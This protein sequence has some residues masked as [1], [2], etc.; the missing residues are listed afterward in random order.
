MQSTEAHVNLLHCSVTSIAARNILPTF[1][2]YF[3][4]TANERTVNEQWRARLKAQEHLLKELERSNTVNQ[5]AAAIR[6]ASD[7]RRV[8]QDG[9]AMVRSWS[10]KDTLATLMPTKETRRRKG[11]RKLPAV[12]VASTKNPTCSSDDTATPREEL[13]HNFT[14]HPHARPAITEDAA[15]TLSQERRPNDN[16]NSSMPSTISRLLLN[17]PAALDPPQDENHLTPSG[18]GG[19]PERKEGGGAPGIDESSSHG[20]QAAADS[21]GWFWGENAP[22][23]G[24]DINTTKSNPG[25]GAMGA[26]WRKARV[27]GAAALNPHVAL[28]AASRHVSAN[29]PTRC[30]E[31]PRQDPSLLAPG[32]STVKLS[33]AD[34]HHSR[35]R[36]QGDRSNSGTFIGVAS[37]KAAVRS[38]SN[39]A[40]ELS[41]LLAEGN[42]P[43]REECLAKAESAVRAAQLAVS[44]SNERM[45]ELELMVGA[46]VAD[47]A[48]PAAGDDGA[49]CGGKENRVVTKSGVV[50]GV[51]VD[52]PGDKRN[53]HGYHVAAAPPSLL[54]HIAQL[55]KQMQ[56]A[57]SL[58]AASL[59]ARARLT[60]HF[61]REDGA[62]T[63]LQARVR[64]F[65]ARSRES[66]RRKGSEMTRKMARPSVQQAEITASSRADEETP[67]YFS[68]PPANASTAVALLSA[69]NPRKEEE[70]A[71]EPPSWEAEEWWTLA[72]EESADEIGD[73]ED[74]LL[75]AVVKLQAIVRSRLSRA[76][77]FAD[78]D[79][80]FVEHFDETY[81][82]PFYVCTETNCSQWNRP[83][84]FGVSLAR[85]DDF[86]SFTEEQ[87]SLAGGGE[88]ES[89]QGGAEGG[90]DETTAQ[91]VETATSDD[92][93]AC[94]Q[95]AAV[96]IQCAVRAARARGRLAE[97]IVSA[98]F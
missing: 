79:A 60:R 26:F 80:R 74:V 56:L 3:C 18:G 63:L 93:P 23:R 51:G 34:G 84:G 75:S 42:N 82:H 62:A 11:R 13:A 70:E 8:V 41:R 95:A 85:R 7:L 4:A 31:S 38:A 9:R 40:A 87:E 36:P 55:T 98:S 68:P 88:E 39:R 29:A 15:V 52:V 1:C 20:A 16:N 5:Q 73:R 59:A 83:F 86:S 25:E 89:L 71:A 91:K 69:N 28:P 2:Y 46:T 50:E 49:D 67:S 78:V 22:H 33:A 47:D 24:G 45:F 44:C 43:P 35:D 27:G 64:G 76:Q 53:E 72:E 48:D 97:R 14:N 65:V 94:E 10:Q 54:L 58:Q 90:G 61:A 92:V 77:T 57:Q 30:R 6:T 17:Y 66:S 81:Q 96:V 19:L 37:T 12:A 21:N 32:E